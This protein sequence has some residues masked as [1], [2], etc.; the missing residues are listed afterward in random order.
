MKIIK[1]M[2]AIIALTLVTQS[3]AT[4]VELGEIK[5]RVEDDVV[6]FEI[7]KELVEKALSNSSSQSIN[8]EIYT[9]IENTYEYK[10]Y[11]EVIDLSA[12]E[13]KKYEGKI[14]VN[15]RGTKTSTDDTLL[16]TLQS[17]GN[18]KFEILIDTDTGEQSGSEYSIN[19]YLKLDNNV[20]ESIPSDHGVSVNIE[21]FKGG[22][23]T[24][25]LIATR[26]DSKGVVWILTDVKYLEEYTEISVLSSGKYK[27]TMCKKDFADMTNYE[28]A[29]TEV[30]KLATIGVIKGTSETT[31]CPGEYIKRSDAILLLVRALGLNGNSTS[32][33][34]DVYI[35]AYYAKEMGIAKELGVLKGD[36]NNCIYPDEYINRQELMDMVYKA[37]KIRKPDF[38][39]KVDEL[40]NFD[41]ISVLDKDKV[42]AAASLVKYG[43]IL[44]NGKKLNPTAVLTRAEAAVIVYRILSIEY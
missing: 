5:T 21:N 29:K 31:Y 4:P 33:F 34:A 43:I 9:D 17:K 38:N 8:R 28:W 42:T 30:E 27:L 35:G 7:T 3:Y 24:A 36:E 2:S 6:Y 23:D 25:K 16:S 32:N 39:G 20:V 19:I 26:E 37:I 12:F 1:L 11:A 13:N 41:D 18:K 40:K 14:S 15:Y 10:K 44:G 22:S